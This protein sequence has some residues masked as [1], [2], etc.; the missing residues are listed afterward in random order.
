MSN[1]E[2]DMMLINIQ[3]SANV[4]YTGAQLKSISPGYKTSL[5]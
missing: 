5:K 4:E 1:K 2:I 3:K